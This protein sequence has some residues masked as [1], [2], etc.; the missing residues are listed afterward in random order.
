VLNPGPFRYN[1]KVQGKVSQD[2]GELLMVE[3]D[4]TRFFNVAGDSFYSMLIAF[5]YQ[6]VKK[7]RRAGSSF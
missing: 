2:W 6:K 4:K 3:I 5:S 7:T 1:A